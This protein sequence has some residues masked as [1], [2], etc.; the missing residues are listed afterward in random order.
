MYITIQG[1]W[2]LGP[3]IGSR[4][5]TEE[6]ICNK[7]QT[8]SNKIKRLA[9]VATSQPHAAYTTFTHGPLKPLVL[10]LE[11]Y[12]RHPWPPVST[13]KWIHQTFIPAVT[14]RH[15]CLKL[16]C[17]LLG[18][19]VRL[20]GMGLTNPVTLSTNAFHGSQC[21]TAPLAA[22]IITQEINQVADPDLTHSLKNSIHR[23][24]WQRQVQLA[25]DIHAQL[26]PQLKH[27]V[28]LAVEQGSSSWLMAL[29]LWP[30][31]LSSQVLRCCLPQIWLGAQE[32]TTDLQLW[33]CIHRWPCH[34]VPHRRLS[35][36]PSWWN[37]GYNCYC[38]NRS[39]P[40]CCHQTTPTTTFRWNSQ[41]LHSQQRRWCM[42]WHQSKRLLLRD[43]TSLESLAGS[44]H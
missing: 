7:V 39:V 36:H 6:Y 10:P 26:T 29:P 28:D 27:C 2:H 14:G 11:N 35:Y 21:L 43:P 18:L 37:P 22:L 40:Q 44:L 17:D 25:K 1:K 9:K 30:W 15:P 42:I 34:D 20:G 38:T 5:F 4:N 31:L 33:S 32:H 24:N 41:P 12:S 16:K 8:W 19:P 13:R 3:A 23:E